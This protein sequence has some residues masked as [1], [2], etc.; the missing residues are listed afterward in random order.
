MIMSH[1]GL[2]IVMNINGIMI[3]SCLDVLNYLNSHLDPHPHTHTPPHPPPPTHT[4]GLPDV[5]GGCFL[6][7]I[8]QNNTSMWR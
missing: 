7:D 5:V 6:K 8:S 1:L 4:Q 3:V 2:E